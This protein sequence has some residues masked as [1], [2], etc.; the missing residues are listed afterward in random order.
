[1]AFIGSNYKLPLKTQTSE[2]FCFGT[3]TQQS[4]CPNATG[5]R[6]NF[7]LIQ[8]ISICSL[9]VD[10]YVLMDELPIMR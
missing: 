7:R 6:Q 2:G 9:F 3:E 1:V 10:S 8:T 4:T 5:P